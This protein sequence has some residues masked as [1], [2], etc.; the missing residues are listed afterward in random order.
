MAFLHGKGAGVLLDAFNLSPFLTNVDTEVS[1]DTPDTTTFGAAAKTC[2]PGLKD[3]KNTISGY[4]DNTATTGS[5]V[6]LSAALGAAAGKTLTICPQGVATIGNLAKLSLTS[7]ANYKL[8]TPVGGIV[9]FS[10]DLPPTGGNL[11]GVLLE[12]LTQK[13]NTGNSASSVDNAALSSNGATANLHCTA[14]TSGTLTAKV[15]H[16][17]DNSAWVDLITFT[18][19]TA[20]GAQQSSVSGT[21]NR[22]LRAS[23]AT[24]FVATFA[25]AAARN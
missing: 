15:Q 20:V 17:V 18:A 3:G 8:G 13:T 10:A 21:V 7:P 19:L 23:W 25:V 11:Q 24:T 22:Y 16:S 14:Y 4:V 6:V 12:P 9:T 2:L 1:V 5:D